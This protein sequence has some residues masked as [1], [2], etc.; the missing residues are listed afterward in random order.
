M[1]CITMM[2]VTPV[3]FIDEVK[4]L[5]ASFSISNEKKKK[6]KLILHNR[7]NLGKNNVDLLGNSPPILYYMSNT[8]TP[9]YKAVSNSSCMFFT[10]NEPFRKIGNIVTYN[11]VYT[12]LVLFRDENDQIIFQ[13]SYKL[14]LQTIYGLNFLKFIV[15][16]NEII[17]RDIS[18]PGKQGKINFEEKDLTIFHKFYNNFIYWKNNS[19]EICHR[20]SHRVNLNFNVLDVH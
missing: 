9:L 15:E 13:F 4:S 6:K 16:Y 2:S 18:Y 20:K 1:L 5:Y 14:D 7:N 19:N 10:H 8:K 17:I 11:A 12:F 3:T